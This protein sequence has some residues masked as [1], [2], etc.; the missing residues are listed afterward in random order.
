M[1]ERAELDWRVVIR[2]SS[3]NRRRVDENQYVLFGVGGIAEK[4]DLISAATVLNREPVD[5]DEVDDAAVRAV[6]ASG[7]LPADDAHL[8]NL[9][10]AEDED[11]E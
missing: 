5:G 6:D 9:E 4:V 10:Y 7:N 11:E 3:R 2:Y 1:E 8:D